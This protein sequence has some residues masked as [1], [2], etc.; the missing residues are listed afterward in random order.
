M[1]KTH[2]HEFTRVF[3]HV[4]HRQNEMNEKF[5]EYVDRATSSDE[6]EDQICQMSNNAN[7]F[8]DAK[9]SDI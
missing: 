3:F 8:T 6:I 2:N 4:A 5:I 7:D 9:S 1:N